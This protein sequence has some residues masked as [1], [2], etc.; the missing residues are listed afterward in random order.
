MRI[1]LYCT[2]WNEIRMLPHFLQ[3]YEQFV[4]RM[5]IFDNMSTDGSRELIASHPQCDLRSLDF[6]TSEDDITGVKRH[7][8]KR[9]RSPDWILCVDIDE[10]IHHPNWGELLPRCK[11]AGYSIL[12]PDGWQV[13]SED[14]PEFPDPVFTQ[15]SKGVKDVRYS[16]WVMFDPKKI[17][18]INY[19]HGCHNANPTGEVVVYR[20]PALRLLHCRYLSVEW[21][22]ER[23]KLLGSRLNQINLRNGWGVH[24]L[25]PE[26]ALR[27]EFVELQNRSVPIFGN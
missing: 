20:D 9:D 8:W 24:Y 4:E 26:A 23:H 25:T 18:E 21:I 17:Q 27:T 14:F 10:L 5:F 16:K 12:A 15:E 7:A 19:N 1:H 6:E 3:H 22:V 13:L 11:Q 2:C